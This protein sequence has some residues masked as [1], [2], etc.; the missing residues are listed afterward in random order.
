MKVV[1]A[2]DFRSLVP[3]QQLLAEALA[4]RG[5]ELSYLTPRRRWLPFTRGLRDSGAEIF[6]LHWL[7]TYLLQRAPMD[8]F[9]KVRFLPDLFFATRQARLV[10]TVHDL[11]PTAS[12]ED[13]LTAVVLG[14]MLRRAPALIFH[15][16]GAL[17]VAS[18]RFGISPEHCAVIP[19][20]DLSAAAGPLIPRDEARTR[21]RL[22]D[23]PLCLAFGAV[24]ENKGLQELV[25]WWV[26]E[27]PGAR[28]AVVGKAWDR[29]LAQ[30]LTDLARGT[31]NV[32]LRFGFAS[33][34]ET[35]AWFSAANCTVTYYTSIFTSGVACLA[36]S[37][38]VPILLPHRLTTIDL[39]EP[40]SSV[41]RYESLAADF[42]TALHRAISRGADYEAAAPWRLATAW[43]TIAEKTAAIYEQVLAA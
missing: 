4:R 2:P 35:K 36:R 3:Y 15:S 43:D 29:S 31:D 30:R 42:G 18:E 25:A 11:F 37:W 16:A 14:I 5:V 27:R 34:E 28:L 26:K 21:L 6:H 22:D 40:H 7:D 20:G 24:L 13:Q 41:F 8:A 33:D 19:H 32:L 10:Y 9:R 23:E 12:V 1:F 38:G 39:A 17:A